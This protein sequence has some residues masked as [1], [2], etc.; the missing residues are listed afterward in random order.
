M[1]IMSV[2]YFFFSFFKVKLATPTANFEFSI[3]FLV[4]YTDFDKGD[5][6]KLRNRISEL[7]VLTIDF[8]FC[9]LAAAC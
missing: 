8:E 4:K 6:F 3:E 1:R 9:W 2:D 7:L 5:N